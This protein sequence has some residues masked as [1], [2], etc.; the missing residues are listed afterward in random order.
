MILS[1]LKQALTNLPIL[2]KIILLFLIWRVGL[3]WV[4][5][6]AGHFLPYD[7]SFPYA[8]EILS[9]FKLLRWIY[10]WANFDGVHYLTIAKKGYVG[11][12]LIQ[13][14][15]PLYPLLIKALSFVIHNQLLAGLVISNL[16]FII[17]LYF[18][19][20]LTKIEFGPKT[21]W[22]WVL[23][24]LTF[25]TSFY[26]GALYTESVFLSAILAS[27][28]YIRQQKKTIS[29]I[30]SGLSSGLRVVG[31]LLLPTIFLEWKQKK[32]NWEDLS[33][34][35]KL[36]KSWTFIFAGIGLIGFMIFLWIQFEDPF[37]FFHVQSEFGAG[38]QESIILLPQVFY[39]YAKILLTVRPIDWKYY[40]YV[41]DFVIS[42]FSLV[43]LFGWWLQRQ[44]QK[45]R[46][47]YLWYAVPA[48]LLPTLTGTLSSMPRYVLVIFPIFMWIADKLKTA[49]SIYRYLYFAISLCLLT[50]N[51][52][53]FI[54]GYWVA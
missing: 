37:F 15:F 53:L 26:F 41:Q 5:T 21:G 28:W 47:S 42:L 49:K 3:F 40:T 19:F 45:Y 1:N 17:A 35:D 46:T 39:R 12:G 22:L 7:P 30:L 2:I 4:G 50:I 13:A 27:L 10:S 36:K 33:L 25:P 29:S 8:K 24:L 31:I 23:I 38:R 43:A 52:V 6:K 20:K 18:G 14:F 54:Q 34:A 51:T 16:S 11:T 32:Q 48:F 9:D 44:Q